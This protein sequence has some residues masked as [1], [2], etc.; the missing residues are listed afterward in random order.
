MSA[1]NEEIQR[2]Q[3]EDLDSL[4]FVPREKLAFNVAINTHC[5]RSQLHCI[6]KTLQQKGEYDLVKHTCFGMLLDFYPQGYFYVGLL[7]SIMIRRITK[8]QSM[9]HE[10]WFAIGKSKARLSKQEFC[11]I[12]GLKFGPMPD[13]FRRLYEVATDGIDARYWNW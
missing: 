7:H 2:R 10:L 5:K 3:Y 8:R 12:T 9:D 6:T 11:L 4:L 13:V 1:M